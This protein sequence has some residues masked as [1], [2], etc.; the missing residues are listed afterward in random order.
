VTRKRHGGSSAAFANKLAELAPKDSQHITKDVTGETIHNTQVVKLRRMAVTWAF[1]LDEVIFSKWVVNMLRLPMMPWDNICTTQATYILD[2]RNTLHE[3]FLKTSSEWLVMLD[4]DVLPPPD[5]LD[6]LLAH[7]KPMVGGWYR[8]KAEPYFP[9]VYDY[10][11]LDAKGIHQYRLRRVP[12][13]G[14][15]SVG[16]AGAGCW[17]MSREVAEAV[18]ERPYSLYLGEDLEICRKVIGAGFEVLID[19]DIACAHAGVALA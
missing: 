13:K 1:P 19:W 4:S 10:H 15:E 7:K 2:A 9:C 12:G 6:R 5:F 14:L 17:L 18:G 3:N 11:E 16:G 8:I